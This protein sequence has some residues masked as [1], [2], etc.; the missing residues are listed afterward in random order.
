M[1][2]SGLIEYILD[3]GMGLPPLPR[4]LSSRLWLWS[5]EMIDQ[6]GLSKGGGLLFIYRNN[7]FN[8]HS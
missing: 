6:Q 5:V 1:A 3:I 7:I 4:P 2:I 8:S